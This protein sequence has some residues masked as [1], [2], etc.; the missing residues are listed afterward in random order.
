[1]E[2]T[3][4]WAIFSIFAAIIA[5]AFGI[6]GRD[7]AMIALSCFAV[8]FSIVSL[9]RCSET[10]YKY[11][12]IMSVSVLICTI[13]MITVASYDTLV[14]GKAMSD[15]WWIYL[16]GAIH[17]AAMIPLTVMFFF[18]TAAL[19]DASYNW[20]LMPGLSWLVGTGFQVPKY[21]MVY[22]V[23]Y[24]DFESGV[25]SNTTLTLTMLV[26]MVMFIVFSLYLRRV[27]KKNLY[28]ITKNGLVRRQ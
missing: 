15:Y 25:I 2:S 13:L 5:L 17:G 19:F 23:Q 22:V 1:M 3:K 4:A 16:S 27:F 9:M 26:N 24:S 20:V 14:N 10:V 21:L 11:S 8:V 6:W 18:V 7:G 28:L 12:V